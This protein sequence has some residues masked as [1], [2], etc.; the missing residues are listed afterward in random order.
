VIIFPWNIAEE[1]CEQNADLR[2]RGT[3]FIRVMPELAFV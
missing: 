3:Q 1:V 2:A